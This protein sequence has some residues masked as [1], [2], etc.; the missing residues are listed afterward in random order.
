[1]KKLFLLAGAAALLASCSNSEE[2]TST[3][4]SGAQANQT[5][6]DFSIY[7]ARST[8]R[9]G[10]PGTITTTSL[11]TGAHKDA[12]FGV[13]GFYTDDSQYNAS[14]SLPNF[15]YN[16]QVK[17]VGD[18]WT[19]EPVKYWPNEFGNG[20]VSDNIDY[21][22]FFAYAP[23]VEVDP[24]TGLPKNGTGENEKNITQV[25]KNTAAGDPI[26]KY[27]VDTDPKTSVDLLY[28]VCGA[29]AKDAFGNTLNG[30]TVNLD[31][32]GSFIDLTKPV[33][34]MAAGDSKIKFNLKHALAK[35]SATVQYVADA[36][37]NMTGPGTAHIGAGQTI[38]ATK[39]RIFIRS[40][41]INGIEMKGALNLHVANAG[42]PNWKDYDGVRDLQFADYTVFYDGRKDGKEG[43]DNGE[44]KNE[45]PQGLNPDLVQSATFTGTPGITAE[46]Q[47]LFASGNG[48]TGDY[49]YVI[50]RNGSEGVNVEIVYDVETIDPNLSTY[51]SDGKTHG[52][53]VQNR[54]LKENIFGTDVD[55]KAGSAY[56]IKLFVGMTSVKV[57]A[58]VV[59][60]ALT[61]SGSS[62]VPGNTEDQP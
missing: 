57:D 55:F 44:Q 18:K 11:Q 6:V 50:P 51:I 34:P 25:S 36:D 49:F 61:Q 33:S 5:A 1:M 20:A 53:S 54:I 45:K 13:F 3:N 14:A 15:M 9:A 60:W 52:I 30:E 47:N 43:T 38:D 56:D 10:E 28:A 58:S 19:Y 35:V 16:Q 21:V 39:T 22:S 23:Y 7:T 12:G 40:F 2:L 8:T 26:V 59:D 46:P 32:G 17:W 41:K 24:G 29:D 48:V 4:S 37:L 42:E 31:E 62:L 27:V